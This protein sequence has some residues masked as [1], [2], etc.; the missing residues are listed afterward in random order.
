MADQRGRRGRVRAGARRR[1]S[2]PAASAAGQEGR[3]LIC[4]VIA[5]VAKQSRTVYAYSGSPHRLR[6][7]AMTMEF[8]E[9]HHRPIR[10]PVH[11]PLVAPG[12]ILL[13]ANSEGRRVGNEW[14]MPVK[15]RCT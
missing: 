4:I 1:D 10:A 9:Q 15:F 5:S 14:V 12:A 7:L 2:R 13:V 3:A 6:L 8:P 11:A